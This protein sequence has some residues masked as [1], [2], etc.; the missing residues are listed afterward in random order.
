LRCYS[1]AGFFFEPNICALKSN[2]RAQSMPQPQ[3]TTLN[4]IGSVSGLLAGFASFIDANPW[5]QTLLT[6]AGVAIVSTVATYYT[7]KVLNWFNRED[8]PSNPAQ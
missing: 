6:A 1:Q 4:A 5:A 3:D 7:R 8:E 2:E